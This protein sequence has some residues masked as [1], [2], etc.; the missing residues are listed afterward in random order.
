MNLEVVVEADKYLDSLEMQSSVSI[1][2]YIETASK[3][4]IEVL[5]GSF[6]LHSSDFRVKE[7]LKYVAWAWTSGWRVSSTQRPKACGVLAQSEQTGL[8]LIGF[9]WS[10]YNK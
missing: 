5:A 3:E 4:S 2:V 8:V 6:S 9:L 7:S 1:F 10:L